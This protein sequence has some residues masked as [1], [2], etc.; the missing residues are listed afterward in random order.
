MAVD[1]MGLCR[2]VQAKFLAGKDHMPGDGGVA[3][4]ENATRGKVG[5]SPFFLFFPFFEAPPYL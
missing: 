1:A 5:G 4:Y 2:D 3:A